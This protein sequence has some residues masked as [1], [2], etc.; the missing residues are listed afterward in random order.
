MEKLNQS[1]SW[2]TEAKTRIKRSES[3]ILEIVEMLTYFSK[4]TSIPRL[5]DKF[6]YTTKYLSKT[7]IIAI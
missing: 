2:L 5:D 7:N 3:L 4:T 6:E 1:V